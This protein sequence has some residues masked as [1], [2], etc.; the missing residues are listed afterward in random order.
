MDQ[1]L[2]ILGALMVLAAFAAAQFGLLDARS[3]PYLLLNMVG[4][5]ILAVLALEERQWG[6]LLLEGVW[7]LVSLTGVLMRARGTPQAA[8]D[9]QVPERAR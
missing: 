9:A 8:A 6:F 3:Y 5:A 4:S 7:S 2:Q 1:V